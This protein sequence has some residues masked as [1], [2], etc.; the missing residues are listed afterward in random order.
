MID[1]VLP[2]HCTR[3]KLNT[4]CEPEEEYVIINMD[5]RHRSVSVDGKM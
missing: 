2:V 1:V 3:A 4:K 5:V